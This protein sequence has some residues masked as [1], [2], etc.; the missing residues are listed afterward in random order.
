[1]AVRA[2]GPDNR[3]TNPAEGK[4]FQFPDYFSGRLKAANL[5]KIIIRRAQISHRG[6][7]PLWR[8]GV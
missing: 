8:R 5:S 6:S 4:P 2:E 1:T 7:R 3:L